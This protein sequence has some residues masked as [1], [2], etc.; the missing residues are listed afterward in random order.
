[1][2]QPRRQLVSLIDTPYYHCVSR[3]VRRAFLCGTDSTTGQ[4]YE[5]R[6]QWVEDRI[7][8]LSSLFAVDICSYAVMSNHYHIVV[9]LS[10]TQDWS[11]QEV[12]RRWLTLHKGPVLVQRYQSGEVLSPAEKNAVSDIIQV[13]RN[14]LQ[15]LSWFMKCLN[16]PIAR[17]ANAEDGCT[18]HFWESRFK[19]QALLSEEALLSCM[20]YVDLN[21]IRARM[22][23]APESSEHTS[24]RE[25][26]QPQ[27]TL[28]EAV[29]NQCLASNFE[30]PIKPLLAFDG[31]ITSARQDGIPYSFSDYLQL[32]DW[33]GRAI[34]Q[35]KRGYIPSSLPPILVRLNIPPGQWLLNS[36]HFEKVVHRR[37]RKAA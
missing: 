36:Q 35:N 18:G 22:A 9:K 5:H 28:A 4:C 8:L 16:E 27:F 6:R 19:S 23:K 1:M 25:R 26:V 37:F 11:D 30:L 32:V 2:T 15:D 20:A 34:R 33:S 21:P 12:L 7:R 14:R 29:K 31:A 24:I 10:A 17:I 13:W 3:C